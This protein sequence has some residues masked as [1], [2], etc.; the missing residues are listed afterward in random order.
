MLRLERGAW[1]MVKITI[2][3]ANI[4]RV[5]LQP[6][7][8]RVSFARTPP[9]PSLRPQRGKSRAQF[10]HTYDKRVECFKFEVEFPVWAY[11]SM[12]VVRLDGYRQGG[13]SAGLFRLNAP[14]SA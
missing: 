11:S 13:D 12:T 2:N 6:P 9:A 14:V 4:K 8:G 10:S 3:K 7:P 1:S 5:R